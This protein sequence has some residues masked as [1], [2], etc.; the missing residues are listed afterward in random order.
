MS[1][2]HAL[3]TKS[4][5][6]KGRPTITAP[7]LRAGGNPSTWYSADSKVHTHALCPLLVVS[8]V[9]GPSKGGA[10]TG[11]LPEKVKDQTVQ[12]GQPL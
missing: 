11:A 10:P 3:V 9:T 2:K 1:P 5:G 4:R 8:R 7:E 12:T 6:S